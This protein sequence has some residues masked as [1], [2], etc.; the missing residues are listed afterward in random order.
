VIGIP[1]TDLGQEV[2]AAVVLRAGGQASVDELRQFVKD[3]VAPYKYPR[4]IHL[5]DELP[6]SHTGKILKRAINLKDCL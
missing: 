2:A 5:V 3:R 1:D 6:K 4:N